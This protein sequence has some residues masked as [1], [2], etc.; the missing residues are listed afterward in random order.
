MSTEQFL[1]NVFKDVSSFFVKTCEKE[2]II[3]SLKNKIDFFL[4]KK[5][6][7]ET[8]KKVFFEAVKKDFEII[9]DKEIELF[10]KEL[11]KLEKN[12]LFLK[13][14]TKLDLVKDTEININRIK[15]IIK[16]YKS[17]K[18]KA[19]NNLQNIVKDIKDE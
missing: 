1:K 5:D 2:G 11:E 17:S 3:D 12:L 18:E 6:F 10:L 19:I 8:S 16:I 4:K 15:D 9:S 13:S 7:S 14:I